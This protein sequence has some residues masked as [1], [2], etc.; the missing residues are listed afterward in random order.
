VALGLACAGSSDQHGLPVGRGSSR[1]GQRREDAGQTPS[2]RAVLAAVE[3]QP[4]ALE[5]ILLRTDLSIAEV[6]TACDELVES[7]SL[8]SGPGW[9]ARV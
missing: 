7:G 5:T 3:F 1:R 8:V 4:T 9:W 2:H 6:A